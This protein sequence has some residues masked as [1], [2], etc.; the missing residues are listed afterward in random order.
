M[1]TSRAQQG[2]LTDAEIKQAV[3]ALEAANGVKL[4]AAKSLN[5]SESSFRRRIN[6]AAERG[7]LGFKPVLPGFAISKTSTTTDGDG[8]LTSQTIATRREPDDA[9]VPF[10]MPK[11]HT[12]GKGTFHVTPDGQ[13]K[14]A[15]L[16]TREGDFD[17]EQFAETCKTAFKDFENRADPTLSP[18]HCD[19]EFLNLIPCNDWHVNLL[20]WWREVGESW[21][22]K[23]AERVIGEAIATVIKSA[24][25]AKTAIVL[26]GGDLMHNDDN[27]NRT[28]KSQAVL[29]ADGRHQKGMEVTLRLMVRTIELALENNEEVIVR[30]LKGNHDEQS[31]VAIAYF[32][33]AWFRNEPRVRVDLDA[34]LFWFY[35]FGKVMLAATHGHTVPIAKLPSIM[36]GRRPEM[37][38]ATKFRYGHGFHVHHKEVISKEAEGVWC[39]THQAPIPQDSWHYGQGYLSGRSVQVITYHQDLGEFGRRREPVQD[40]IVAKP[41][42][43]LRE[44]A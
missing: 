10:E 18:A 27:T 33:Y 6:A 4:D 22:L 15:W 40:A 26:G 29:D 25:R 44:A 14:Q 37:W 7:L 42:D 11:G 38:G 19:S 34:S 31:S 12:L 13:L 5:L 21:D 9:D 35:Q 20:T 28:A 32:L 1:A 23:I 41:T 43:F 30:I 16:K 2:P 17:P 36:A 3:E 39:E 8:N 24:R